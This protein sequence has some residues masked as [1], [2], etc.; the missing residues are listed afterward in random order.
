[1][2]EVEGTWTGT[3]RVI[4]AL[5]SGAL[6]VTEVEG[7]ESFSDRVVFLSFAQ[8]IGLYDYPFRP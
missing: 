3:V 7:M 5:P 8:S 6:S 4:L 1:M 2:V